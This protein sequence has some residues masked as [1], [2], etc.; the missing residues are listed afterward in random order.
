MATIS[1]QPTVRG[2]GWLWML[3]MVTS[4]A[5]LIAYA[6]PLWQNLL[7]DTPIA[8]LIWIPVLAFGWAMWN[9]Q[10]AP[11]QA[12]D[13][14]EL[15]LILGA[16][17]A[18]LTGM[19]LVVG[20]ERWPSFFVFDHGGLL[21]WPLWLLATTWLFWG[22]HTTRPL[23]APLVYLLLVWPPIFEGVANATQSILVR[24][25]V[26]IL[27][28][29]SHHVHWL[30]PVQ[31]QT[32]GT[33][34]VTYHSAPV[35]VVVA[36]ACSGADS[37][38]AAAIVIPM[39]WFL[40]HG[41]WPNKAWLSGVALLGALVLNWIRLA[42]I[43]ACVHVVGPGITFAYIHP[44][45]GF[46]LFGLLA[47]GIGLLFRPF[48]LSLPLVAAKRNPVRPGWA[49]IV[50]ATVMAGGVL[51]LIWPLTG[52][53]KGAFG[54]PKPV[55][56][57][58]ARTFLPALPAFHQYGIYYA[59][60]SSV[61]GPGSATEADSY[62]NSSGLGG[63][64]TVEMWSTPNA[65]ALAT[66]GFHACLLYHGDVL[67]AVRSFQLV[68][69]VLA[70]AYAVSLPPDHVGGRRTTYVDIE[71]SD[72]ILVHGSV[73]YLRWSIAT[74]PGQTPSL[75]VPAA[76]RHLDALTPVEAMMAPASHGIWTPSTLQTRTVLAYLASEIF[77]RSLHGPSRSL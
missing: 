23:V 52:L 24:W 5:P 14:R 64:T 18:L 54:N 40:L 31:A 29:V 55:A 12:E 62:V 6:S 3:W 34:A 72:A 10:M 9:I 56:Q 42:I 70:A 61:L 25:A 77:H 26:G 16:G 68:P 20:P 50:T 57:F 41:A 8:D 51:L 11:S 65:G 53:P 38:L 74:F 30:R 59:N 21:L 47:V 71:W 58:Q 13:D 28:L 15:D 45:L 43:V 67:T 66:Y 76:A 4:A 32:F 27:T 60:E 36:Q 19:A 2:R 7:A 35:L 75:R 69:G 73:R 22:L 44:V 63:Q 48:H 46:V 1:L 39:I 37:L 17:L 49:R 33:F